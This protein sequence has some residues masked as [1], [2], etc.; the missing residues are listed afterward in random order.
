MEIRKE[1]IDLEDSFPFRIID[2]PIP[3][4]YDMGRIFHWHDCLEISYVMKGR[5]RYY[6]ED[7][8][9][10]MEPGDVIIINNAEPH[11]LEV[12][13]DMTQPVIVFNPCFILTDGSCSF[14]H[15]Y[16]APFFEDDRY[17]KNKINVNNPRAYMIR[18]SI[19]MIY[20]EYNQKSYGYKMM[21]KSMLLFVLTQLIRFF[22]SNDINAENRAVKMQNLENIQKLLEYM[23]NNFDSDI[24]LEKAAYMAGFSPQYFSVF[25]KKM[26]GT[27]FVKYLNALRVGKAVKLLQETDKKI[28]HIANECGFNNTANFNR[29]F[30]SMTGR[31][32]SDYR[33]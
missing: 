31:N 23:N 18:T 4:G 10:D 14:E 16:L 32:P 11:Y 28:I 29:I 20:S 6:I 5:G 24:S 25:F 27:T 19:Q 9:Y 15:E 8:I 13:E 17:F 22:A 12:Y 3:A 2:N 30:K 21:I 7:R 33:K 26:T 1:Y